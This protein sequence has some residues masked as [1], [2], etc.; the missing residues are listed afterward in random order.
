MGLFDGRS[1]DSVNF[2]SVYLTIALEEMARIGVAL[3]AD[4][5]TF[6]YLA[7]IGDLLATSMSEHSHNRRLGQLLAE[8][9]NLDQIKQDM[10]VLPE[11]FN[12]LEATLFLAEKTHVSLPLA[13]G[14]WDVIHNRIDVDR[15]ITCFIREPSGL[16]TRAPVRGSRIRMETNPVINRMQAQTKRTA[17]LKVAASEKCL[18]R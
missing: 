14:L 7:G 12:T 11:G 2:R 8:G 16:S 15:F 10:G 1:I 9:L 4:Q 13:K 17:N 6:L 3:G 18:E 5:S